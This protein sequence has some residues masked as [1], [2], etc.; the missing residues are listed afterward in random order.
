MD[1]ILEAGLEGR[2]K[3]LLRDKP[4]ILQE[5]DEWKGQNEAARE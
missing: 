2:P 5:W 4:I 3:W 1:E